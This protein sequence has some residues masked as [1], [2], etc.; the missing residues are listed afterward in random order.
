MSF[1]TD[2]FKG[3]K[4][5]IVMLYFATFI[6][7]FAA[8]LAIALISYMVDA[9]P[10]AFVIAFYSLT[11]IL[12]VS[13]FGV[14]ADRRGRRPVLI[15][16][17]LLTT[18][19]VALFAIL[20]FTQGAVETKDFFIILVVYFPLMGILGAGAASKVASTMTMI[21]DESTIETRAQY[22]GFFDLAT[23]GGFAAGL[24]TGHI[25]QAAL[26]VEIGISFTIAVIVVVISLIMVYYLVD[27]TL[28]P[29]ELAK[30]QEN[31]I[32]NS[33]FLTR[34][35][36]VVR[37]NKDLQKILPVYVPMISLYG[38][39]VAYAKE[40]AEDELGAGISPDLIL[41]AIILGSTMGVSMLLSGKLSD[42]KLVRRPFIIIGLISL[43][44]LIIL[45]RLFSV[46]AGGEGSFA[47]LLTYWPVTALLGFGVGMF[48]PA[49]LAYLT[50]ISRKDTR[51]TMFGVYSVIFGSG[52]IIGPLLG[53]FFAE[54]GRI[55]DAEIW[56]LVIAVVLLVLL[57]SIGT[58]FIEEKAKESIEFTA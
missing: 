22:M 32:K 14:S 40:L 8:Y 4:F 57:S 24:A 31:E 56:G 49:I 51:G 7:R 10:R 25:L 6:M 54:I 33:E 42:T 58:L 16:S 37:T 47:G 38:L 15:V 41:V 5:S 29:E 50:D 36:H 21:A 11:E 18:I 46:E 2:I 48:P 35:L 1:V 23:L 12:T 20:A 34:V 39:L 26:D 45:F 53:S 9:T 19:G 27:E 52:M 43:A 55:Y 13:F 44:I 28:N 17:H 3:H 30:A